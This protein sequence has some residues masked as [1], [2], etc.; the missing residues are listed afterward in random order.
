MQG[1]IDSLSSFQQELITDPESPIRLERQFAVAEAQFE[2]VAARARAGDEEAISNLQ[3]AAQTYLDLA[4]RTGIGTDDAFGEV[5][6]ALNAT[7]SA[8][9]DD[10]SAAEQQLQATRDIINIV[11]DI[12]EKTTTELRSIWQSAK[13]DATEAQNI[14]NRI[15]LD[16]DKTITELRT[17]WQAEKAQL[18]TLEEQKNQFDQMIIND[19]AEYEKLQQLLDSNIGIEQAI[20]NLQGAFGILGRFDAPPPAPAPTP[21]PIPTPEPLG[22]VETRVVIEYQHLFDRAPKEEGLDYWTDALESGAVGSDRL[23]EALLKGAASEDISAFRDKYVVTEYQRLFD[24]Q[25][26]EEGLDY[27]TEALKSDEVGS[28]RLAEALLKGAASEDISAFRDEYGINADITGFASGGTISGPDSG[29]MLPGVEF[30]GTE[31][32][33]PDSQMSE[34]KDQNEKIIELLTMMMNTEGDQAKYAKKMWRILD[35]ASRGDQP[36]SMEAVA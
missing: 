30:H 4:R 15:A 36:I 8:V 33:T 13:V 24:R 26:K 31:H 12:E 10:L 1:F 29:Y 19:F 25:P 22:D 11:K 27:W 34:I 32:I 6:K 17:I 21:E 35:G 20:A 7:Q 23:A 9:K 5:Q 16:G 2:G 18:V 28:D 3:S 14:L